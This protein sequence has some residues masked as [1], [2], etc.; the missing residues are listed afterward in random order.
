MIRALMSLLLALPLTSPFVEASATATSL[1]DGL[2]L[3]VSVTVEGS[4]V[5]VVVRGIA[6]G[7][8][9]LP[10]VALADRGDGR[11]EGIVQLPVA[12]NILVAFEIIPGRG[13]TAISDAHTLTELGVD[14]AIFSMDNPDTAFGE[15]SG[16]LVS[17]ESARWGWI[18][19]A[20]G[21][22]ALALIS[23]WSVGSVRSRN[24]GS[25][26]AL[27]GAVSLENEASEDIFETD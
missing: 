4:P 17:P 18:S 21:A 16:P 27:D 1:D 14:S 22:A 10:P 26:T 9:E 7:D 2:W 24:G 13:P 12:E 8:S 23:Y 3:D 5:A 25:A 11:W 15:D 19:L 6:P 20:A